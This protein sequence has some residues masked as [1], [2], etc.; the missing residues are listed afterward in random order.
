M[1]VK[2]TA[3]SPTLSAGILHVEPQGPSYQEATLNAGV[4]TLQIVDLRLPSNLAF[5]S[6]VHW[7][8]FVANPGNLTIRVYTLDSKGNP[9]EGVVANSFQQ[10]SMV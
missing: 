5:A 1:T 8:V 9:V 2:D 6:R 3:T 10:A 7:R 4:N